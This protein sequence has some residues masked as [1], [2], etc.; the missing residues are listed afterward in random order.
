VLLAVLVL[1]LAL[2]LGVAAYYSQAES[3]TMVSQNSKAQSLAVAKA[4]AGLQEAVRQLR[5]NAIDPTVIT[6]T[7][8]S[9]EVLNGVCPNLNFIQRGPYN[10]GDADAGH[11]LEMGDALQYQYFIYKPTGADP[12][13]PS[14]R[15]VVQV[16]GFCGYSLNSPN[17]VTSVVE[18]EVDIGRS[19]FAFT[20]TNGY[21]E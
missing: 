18:A 20:R 10:N 1:L 14:N 9:Q 12:G 13:M 8:T 15:F 17:L 19:G 4:E 16:H 21:D 3:W 6:G 2:S 7:C 5:S 11:S